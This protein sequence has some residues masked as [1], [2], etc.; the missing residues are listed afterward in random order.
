MGSSCHNLLQQKVLC[1]LPLKYAANSLT[2]L[3]PR[4]SLFRIKHKEGKP[5]TLHSEPGL[6]ERKEPSSPRIVHL[7][8]LSSLA[9]LYFSRRYL[10][11]AKNLIVPYRNL[12]EDPLHFGF[13]TSTGK[14]KNQQGFPG[15]LAVKNL[16]ANAGDM[17]S[18]PDPGRSH[19]PWS[20]TTE[21]V[22]CSHNYWSAC[23]LEPVLCNKRWQ[24]N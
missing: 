16:L 24:G 18:S 8:P 3:H 13:K 1:F 21:P 19:M 2:P 9:W 11:Q 14:K 20:T 5:F 23:A 7:I 10:P 15:S 17:G 6:R 12:L 4:G 22:L